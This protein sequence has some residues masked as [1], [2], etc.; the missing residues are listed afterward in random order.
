QSITRQHIKQARLSFGQLSYLL[1][2][3]EPSAFSR[4]FKRWFGVAPSKWKNQ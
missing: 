1:G 3:S 4:A 2:Y